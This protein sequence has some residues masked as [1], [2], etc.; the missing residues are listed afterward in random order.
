[1]RL[2]VARPRVK[3]WPACE[4]E[5]VAE[6]VVAADHQIGTGSRR[7]HRTAAWGASEIVAPTLACRGTAGKAE[8][9]QPAD[10]R[11][12]TVALTFVRV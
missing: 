12:E 8:T 5:D 11:G 4:R 7:D 1:M 9:K 2:V 3:R 6:A 10:G